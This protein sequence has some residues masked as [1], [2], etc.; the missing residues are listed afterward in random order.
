MT[1]QYFL[2]NGT[3]I[4]FQDINRKKYRGTLLPGS[5]VIEN[6]SESAL[7]TLQQFEHSLFGIGHR[8]FELFA[9]VKF[10]VN[11]REG[12]RLEALLS[13]EVH[14]IR[15]DKKIKLKAGQYHLTDVPLFTSLFK[16]TTS[17][18][19]FITYFSKELLE[20]LGLE[21]APCTPLKMPERMNYLIKEIL[22]NPYEENLRNFY[23]LNSVRELLFFHLTQD[24]QLTPGELD[25]RDIAAI[26]EADEIIAS[27]LQQ[28]YTIDKLSRM[29]GTNE[30]KLKKGFKHIFGM[31]V[32]HRLLFRRMEQAKV[33]LETTDKSIGDIAELAGYDTAAGFI[34]AFRREFSMTPREWRLASR[35]NMDDKHIP[36]YSV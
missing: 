9:K 23:Y 29:T 5:A 25:N 26:Y 34:H 3:R 13:G 2:P 8:I 21:V 18:S 15:N 4:F 31:G 36:D 27:D 24:K 19:I 35:N 22:R 12:L 17:C 28:H 20:Q 16:K 1:V 32:F 30:F 6:N 11:E 10:F 7:I 33:L 14:V